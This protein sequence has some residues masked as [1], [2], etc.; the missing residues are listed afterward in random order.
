MIVIELVLQRS[1]KVSAASERVFQLRSKSQVADL[2]TWLWFA[3]S[4]PLRL[5]FGP[6]ASPETPL[7]NLVAARRA[8]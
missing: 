6:R 2:A 7:A 8:S 4:P 1:F 5:N 3:R